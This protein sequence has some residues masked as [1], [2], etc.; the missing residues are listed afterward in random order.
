ML[1][2]RRASSC[3]TFASLQNERIFVCLFLSITRCYLFVKKSHCIFSCL[4]QL[5]SQQQLSISKASIQK[6]PPYHLFPSPPR[7]FSPQP[8]PWTTPDG[9]DELQSKCLGSFNLHEAHRPLLLLPL[10]LRTALLLPVSPPVLQNHHVKAN[11]L[12][13]NS[14][15]GLSSSWQQK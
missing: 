4:V 9:L 10:L 14:A 7:T 8:P 5:L 13:M 1:C 12:T 2:I 15:V 6:S 11:Y 3:E